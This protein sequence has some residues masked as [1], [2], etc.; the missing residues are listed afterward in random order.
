MVKTITYYACALNAA[1]KIEQV[2]V[3]RSMLGGRCIAKAQCWT[4]VV[5]RSNKAAAADLARMNGCSESGR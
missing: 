5:Y 3:E 1:G 4:G 2:K